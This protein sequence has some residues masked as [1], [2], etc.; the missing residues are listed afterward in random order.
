MTCEHRPTTP[1]YE[2]A[3][4]A[5]D[6]HV[7]PA[8]VWL[9]LH[10]NAKIW[11]EANRAEQDQIDENDLSVL[12]ALQAFPAKKWSALCSA[13][14]WTPY[15]ISA[16]SWC[17]DGNIH[18]MIKGWQEN[19]F[20]LTPEPV[21]IRPARLMNPALIPASSLLSDF[22]LAGNNN[23]TQICFYIAASQNPIQIDVADHAL[24]EAAP[25]LADFLIDHITRLGEQDKDYL[26]S[27]EIPL[28]TLHSVFER[29]PKGVY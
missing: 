25:Q 12:S 2:T 4:I 22:I 26:Q 1:D 7:S 6:G 28:K 13:L 23:N 17:Q 27:S 19:D 29:F 8:E 16:L 14:G 5:L 10:A 18:D 9:G 21:S 11:P 24:A 20:L 15:G 3:I